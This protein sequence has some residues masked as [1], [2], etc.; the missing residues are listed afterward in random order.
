MKK[1][2]SELD[3]EFI[4]LVRALPEN[5]HESMGALWVLLEEEIRKI[6]RKGMKGE[7][8]YRTIQTTA[9]ANEVYIQLVND[10][11]I[12]FGTRVEFLRIVKTKMMH[13]LVE[14]AR[15]KGAKKR[16][17][18]VLQVTDEN[19]L[20]ESQ[21]LTDSEQDIEK[22]TNLNRAFDKLADTDKKQFE[23]LYYRTLV[24][25]HNSEVAQF[26]GISESEASK[27]V[28]KAKKFMRKELG[29]HRS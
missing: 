8:G 12:S 21:A 17:G 4:N 20:E 1:N 24:F 26:L 6:A 2:E 10:D 22:L 23:A 15:K 18:G 14:N 13:I 28:S 7:R 16:W 3:K 27:R 29:N 5:H 19:A 9:L 11:K 25:E